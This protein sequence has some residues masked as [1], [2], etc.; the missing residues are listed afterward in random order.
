AY[1]LT[2]SVTCLGIGAGP[3]IGGSVAAAIGIRWPFA[4]LGFFAFI[5]AALVNHMLGGR[6]YAFQKIAD[7]D[8][9]IPPLIQTAD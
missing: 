2:S 9:A 1:G 3:A 8:D 4:L 7:G 6:K 5:L